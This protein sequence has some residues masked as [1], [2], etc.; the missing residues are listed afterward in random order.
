[1]RGDDYY[2][3]AGDD[4]LGMAYDL[5]P[6]SRRMIVTF[7]AFP[8]QMAVRPFAFMTMFAEIDVKAAFIRDHWECWY[9]RGVKGVGDGIDAVAG[10]LRDFVRNAEETVLLGTSS[11]GYA[12]ILFG[13]LLGCEAHAFS[14]Q[15]FIDPELRRLHDDKRFVEQM[16]GLG[17]D[18]DM[19]YADLR[20]VVARGAAPIHIYYSTQ[21]RVDPAHAEHVGDL[22]N[23]T[24]HGFDWGSHLLVRELRDRGWLDPFLH[25]L[26]SGRR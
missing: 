9:H 3:Q 20:P 10:F 15:L 7:A 13:A 19:R 26:A 23:V 17:A 21:H 1:M 11:G 24:L 6:H 25:Q 5:S 2:R 4:A 14:P 22:E 18:M 16:E 8:G 12:A